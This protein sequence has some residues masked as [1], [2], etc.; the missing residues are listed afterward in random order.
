MD[1]LFFL[2]KDAQSKFITLDREGQ[3]NF[4][5]VYAPVAFYQ[6]S[7]FCSIFNH[8]VSEKFLIF[9]KFF[10]KRAKK[11]LCKGP[12]SATN[13][14]FGMKMTPPPFSKIHLF[15]RRHPSLMMSYA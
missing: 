3:N 15:W 1:F 4:L 5:S 8:E 2:G 7:K 9:G 14:Y 12:K 13:I 10:R 6:T 11:N